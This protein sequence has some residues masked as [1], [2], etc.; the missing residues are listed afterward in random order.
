[1]SEDRIRLCGCDCGCA[2][3]GACNGD[4]MIEK[5]LRVKSYVRSEETVSNVKIVIAHDYSPGEAVEEGMFD[6]YDVARALLR[7]API[8]DICD[9]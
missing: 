8:F 2:R 3:H 9:I 1:M 7:H 5:S 4:N 6:P